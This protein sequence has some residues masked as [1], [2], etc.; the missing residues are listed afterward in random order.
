M[1]YLLLYLANKL[2]LSTHNFVGRFQHVKST[3]NLFFSFEH[4]LPLSTTIN[5]RGKIFSSGF[6]LPSALIRYLIVFTLFKRTAKFPKKKLF[7]FVDNS[8]FGFG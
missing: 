4:K 2:L 1:L 6:Q 8:Y 3:K 5:H 7:D